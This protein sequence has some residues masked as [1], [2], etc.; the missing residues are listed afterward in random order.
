MHRPYTKQQIRA[1]LTQAIGEIEGEWDAHA[2]MALGLFDAEDLPGVGR[3]Y[4]PHNATNIFHWG[5]YRI[6]I[7]IPRES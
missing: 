3:I 1:L 4:A 6:T 7:S 2:Q 5:G